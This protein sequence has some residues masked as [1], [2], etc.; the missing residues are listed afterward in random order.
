MKLSPFSLSVKIVIWILILSIQLP[1][2]AQDPIAS[3]DLFEMDI[4]ELMNMDV[5]AGSNIRGLTSRDIPAS[6]YTITAE[7]IR[8]TGARHLGEALMILVP[9]FMWT[10]DEDDYIFA[11]RGLTQ[12]NNSS[13]MLTVNGQ[14]VGYHYNYGLASQMASLDLNHIEH[15]DILMG[16]G[17]ADNGSGPL[18]ATINVVT[19]GFNEKGSYAKAG[20][21][22]G[23]GNLRNLHGTVHYDEGGDFKLHL[24]TAFFEQK[25]GFSAKTGDSMWIVPD[26]DTGGGGVRSNGRYL[27]ILPGQ[28][29][30]GR[31]EY[32]G[33]HTSFFHTNQY[34]DPYEKDT[35]THQHYITEGLKL[36]KTYEYDDSFSINAQGW[37]KRVGA[38]VRNGIQDT[39]L[40]WD[41]QEG[42]INYGGKLSGQ[43]NF[44]AFK[45]VLGVRYNHFDYGKNPFTDRNHQRMIPGFDTVYDLQGNPYTL[46][47]DRMTPSAGEFSVDDYDVFAEVHYTLNENHRFLASTVYSHVDS[48][49]DNS[50]APRIAYFGNSGDVSWKLF[51]TRAYKS[52]MDASY[53]KLA[54]GAFFRHYTSD[55][56]K[57]QC[58]DD[59]ELN[60]SYQKKKFFAELRGFYSV[61]KNII[62]GGGADLALSDPVE[63]DKYWWTF[64]NAGRVDL[65]GIEAIVR[66]NITRELSLGASHALVRVSSLEMNIDTDLFV[67]SA[68]R[69]F[70]NYPEDVTRLYAV[71]S[72]SQV[73]GLALRSDFL[74][75]YGRLQGDA[76]F[77]DAAPANNLKSD[78]WYNLNLGVIYNYGNWEFD[79]HLY[80]LLD[81]RPY[82]PVT[83]RNQYAA[84][85]TPFSWMFG[86]SHKFSF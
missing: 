14:E 69:K 13:V 82:Q 86:V 47:A 26:G 27:Q 10:I 25:S 1:V 61:N 18:M 35:E 66:A 16:P 46:P 8:Q 70:L 79:F 2:S 53:L 22:V 23:T 30:Y 59:F 45:T 11:F 49:N 36:D 52:V 29:L 48:R 73:P 58:I 20:V 81:S 17:G 74:I 4:E 40:G 43:Y 67:S 64:V 38:W 76:L 6:V 33:Y 5:S 85:P 71:Y 28:N 62:Q 24:D 32:K 12:D 78:N 60:V 3:E 41:I 63:A 7:D 65:W 54:P 39:T 56:L 84:T 77:S 80:N 50:L 19:T 21:D 34:F 31:A 37:F 68:Q 9:G 15:V 55:E 57:K 44:D 42:E 83:F 75:D 51:Y 72:P